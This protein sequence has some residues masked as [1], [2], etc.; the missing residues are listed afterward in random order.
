MTHTHDAA[1]RI[2]RARAYAGHDLLILLRVLDNL[3]VAITFQLA[4]DDT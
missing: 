1:E 3:T 2:M 4:G